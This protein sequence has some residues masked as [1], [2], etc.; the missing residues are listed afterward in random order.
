MSCTSYLREHAEHLLSMLGELKDE[1][2]RYM[3]KTEERL[4][5]MKKQWRK[6]DENN[7]DENKR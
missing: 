5:G 7:D 1:D 6:T 3:K 2:R 4:S